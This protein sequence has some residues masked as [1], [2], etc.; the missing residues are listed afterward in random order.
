MRALWAWAALGAGLCAGLA[1]A[2]SPVA[3]R[4]CTSL[5]DSAERIRCYEQDPNFHVASAIRRELACEAPPRPAELIRL[6][7]RRNAISSLA[8]HMADGVNYFAVPRPE[9]IDGLTIVAVFAHDE[10]G[11]FPF[12]RARGPSPGTVFGIVTREDLPAIDAWRLRHSPALLFDESQSSMQGAKDIGC[13]WL[14]RPEPKANGAAPPASASAPV[15]PTG[16]GS[17]QDDLFEAGLGPKRR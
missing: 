9:T 12:M 11:R 14:P 13:F 1:S 16:G 4:S 7:I 15:L 17:G 2:Q 3:P 8:F 5:A 6:L 10:T